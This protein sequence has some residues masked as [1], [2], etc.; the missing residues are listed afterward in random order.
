MSLKIY[1]FNRDN[2]HAIFFF[3]V[4]QGLFVC[5]FDFKVILKLTTHLSNMTESDVIRRMLIN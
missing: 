3:Q 2:D 1:I 5:E 4:D